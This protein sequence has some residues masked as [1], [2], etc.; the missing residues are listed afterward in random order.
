[1]KITAPKKTLLTAI[2]RIQGIVEK[3][4]IKPIT[5]NAFIKAAS[6]QISVTATN[7]Q[8]GMTAQYSDVKV[9][10]EGVISVNARKL[11]EVIKE[12]P[13]GEI[14]IV[15]KENYWI[16]ITSGKEVKFNIIGLPPEDFPMI[17]KEKE[18]EYVPWETEKILKMLNLTSF[19]MSKDETNLN[20]HGAF[21]EKIEGFFTRI[22]TTDGYRLSIVDEKIEKGFSLEEGIIIPYKAA[23]ELYK[24]LI[25]KKDEKN[26]YICATKNSFFVR[27]GEIEFVIRLIDKKFPDYRVIIPGDGYKKIIIAVEK[28]K[29]KATLKRMSIISS[30]NNRPVIF[31]CKGSHLEIYTEDSDLGNVKEKI[32][33][34]EKVKEEFKFCINCIYLLDILNAVDEDIVIEYNAEEEN[35]PIIV[36]PENKKENVKYIVMPMLM[37]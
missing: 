31:S 6:S 2:A 4:S 26:A 18:E 28:E 11:F 14:S 16:E 20:I 7:L 32:E 21:L 34:K 30:E 22:V 25:E 29:I 8:I 5:S 19:S 9:I 17:F 33:L 12:L 3:S 13:E 37:D 36:K 27:I 23:V 1:M 24:I 35:K 15:E 10:E